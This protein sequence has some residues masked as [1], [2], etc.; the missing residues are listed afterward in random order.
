MLLRVIR[1]AHV[2]LTFSPFCDHYQ[3]SLRYQMQLK[4]EFMKRTEKLVEN[5]TKIKGEY[6][7]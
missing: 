4:E 6:I 1:K 2:E 3:Y 7:G 5:E